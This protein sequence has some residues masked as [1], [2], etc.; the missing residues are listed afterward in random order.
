MASPHDRA[1]SEGHKAGKHNEPETANPY[2]SGTMQQAWQTGWKA[3][4]ATKSA[5]TG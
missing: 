5:K 1:W 2:G 3:G 4:Q